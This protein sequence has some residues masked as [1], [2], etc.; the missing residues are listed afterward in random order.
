MNALTICFII[1]ILTIIG[2]CSGKYSLAV[3]ALTSMMAMTLTGCL[4]P[5]KALG[6]F[7]NSNVIMVGGMCVVAAGF[8]KTQFCVNLAKR[9]SKLSRG[10]VTRMMMGYV[11]IGVIL[12]Q[13][14]QSPVVVFSVV[15]PMLM[16]TAEE[17]GL[18][19]T[20]VLFPIGIA[21][22]ATCCI[23]PVGAGATVPAEL[24]GYLEAYGYTAH[25]VGFLD[26]MIGRLP[27]L[28]IAIVYFGIFSIKHLPMDP[29]SNVQAIELKKLGKSELS[30][31]QEYAAIIIFFGDALALMISDQLGMASWEITLIGALLMV[32]CN[33][34]KPAEAGKALPLRILFLIVGSNAIAGA[35]SATGAGE[36]IGSMISGVVAQMG[37]SNYLLGTIFFIVPFI[38][39]QFM[40]NRGTML[41]FHPIAIA[42]CAAMGGNPVGL[43]ILIQS[44]CLSAFMTPMSTSA[45]P[46]I[47]GLGGYDV[48]FM[49]KHG[50]LFAIISGV[51]SVIWTMTLFPVL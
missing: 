42:T 12:S 38:Q 45:T 39:T 26:P 36:F 8:N 44:A 31:F 4:E 27:M 43:M 48:K 40:S 51:V 1:F 15:A 23:L 10:S 29:P 7:A 5:S 24:N 14:I 47:M 17:M 13:F 9:V 2:Y 3:F 16:A 18:T 6:Y 37:N 11:L 46:Y 20:K 21:T 32:L 35:L 49:V 33:V 25:E 19:P 30:K 50:T 34:L 22:I 41:I 28:I